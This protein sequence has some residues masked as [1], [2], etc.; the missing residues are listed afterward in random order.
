LR[1]PFPP[2]LDVMDFSFFP[3]LTL[4]FKSIGEVERGGDGKRE[5]SDVPGEDQKREVVSTLRKRTTY[6]QSVRHEIMA[7]ALKRTR[8]ICR[9]QDEAMHIN[10]ELAGLVPQI[11]GADKETCRNDYAQ[12]L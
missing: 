9:R 8:T 5:I 1:L 7:G 2:L 4:W 3:P 6:N 11:I 12:Q 10:R